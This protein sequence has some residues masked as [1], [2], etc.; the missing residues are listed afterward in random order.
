MNY[1]T[2]VGKSTKFRLYYRDLLQVTTMRLDGLN[3]K[4]KNQ[5]KVGQD[6]RSNGNDNYKVP[7]EY[8]LVK[9]KP[10]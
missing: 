2:I 10:E 7:N 6:L 4:V 8:L 9:F 1:K 5:K 3:I